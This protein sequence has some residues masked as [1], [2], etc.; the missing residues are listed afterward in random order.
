MIPAFCDA[1]P[2]LTLSFFHFLSAF[3][4]SLVKNFTRTLKTFFVSYSNR[5]K[6][7][8]FIPEAAKLFVLANTALAV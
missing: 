5:K 4:H 7:T 1:Q 3:I 8:F 6:T 2:V